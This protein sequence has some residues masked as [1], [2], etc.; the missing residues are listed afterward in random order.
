[1]SSAGATGFI[2]FHHLFTIED[3][4]LFFPSKDQ[5]LMNIYIGQQ[6]IQSNK[7]G[8]AFHKKVSDFIYWERDLQQIEEPIIYTF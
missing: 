7:F 8:M 2:E 4:L 1:M 3:R 6:K 5:D